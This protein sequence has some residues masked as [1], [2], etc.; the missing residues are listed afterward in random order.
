MN[1]STVLGNKTLHFSQL[2]LECSQLGSDIIPGSY[3][4]LPWLKEHT[5]SFL[6]SWKLKE[7]VSREQ[8][9]ETNPT[10]Y[11]GKT[12]WTSELPHWAEMKWHMTHLVGKWHEYFPLFSFVSCRAREINTTVGA[13]LVGILSGR[14]PQAKSDHHMCIWSND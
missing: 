7:L 2:L 9:K 3:I 11:A 5:Y 13:C 10:L 14:H 6:D 12:K 4:R 1:G 8:K